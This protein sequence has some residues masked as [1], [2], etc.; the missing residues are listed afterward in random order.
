MP[1]DVRAAFD[2]YDRNHNG[3]LDFVELR[4]VLADMG[5]DY[6]IEQVE[7]VLRDYDANRS[8]QMEIDEFAQLVQRLRT[9]GYHLQQQPHPWN[10]PA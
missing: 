10:A 3:K 8:G 9:L 1:A 2:K 5:I 6:S 4:S 7:Q